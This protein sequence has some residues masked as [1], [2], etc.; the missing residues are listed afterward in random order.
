[1]KKRNKHFSFDNTYG[2]CVI[3]NMLGKLT[4]AEI[5]RACKD[6]NLHFEMMIRMPE[7]P[8]LF[9]YVFRIN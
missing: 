6:L 9:N 2:E 4:D 7:Y 3:I 8:N 1:M 5:S